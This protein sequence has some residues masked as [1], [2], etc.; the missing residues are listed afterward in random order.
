[1]TSSVDPVPAI[2]AY[3]EAARTLSRL[4]LSANSFTEVMA[5]IRSGLADL[6]AAEKI[7]VAVWADSGQYLQLL[8][9]SFGAPDDLVA[10]SQVDA[11]DQRSGAARVMLTGQAWFTNDAAGHIPGFDQWVHGFGI[12]QL[13]TV[14]LAVE[15][16]RIGV[17]HL[18][19]SPGGFRHADIDV[20]EDLVPFIA[21][22]VEHV[23]RRLRSV[24]KEQLA[25]TIAES[26]AGVASGQSLQQLAAGPLDRFRESIGANLLWITF[27]GEKTARVALKRGFVPSAL[28][29]AFFA[30]AAQPRAA[31]RFYLERPKGVGDAGVA[32]AHVPVVVAGHQQAILSVLRIPGAPFSDEER[33]SLRRLANVTALAWATETY[34]RERAQR[35]RMHERQRIADD[36]HDDVAQTLFSAE[37]TLQSLIEDLGPEDN[38]LAPASRA[39]DL[40]VRGEL[41]LRSAIH[42]LTAPEATRLVDRLAELVQITEEEFAVPVRLDLGRANNDV[43]DSLSPAAADVLLRA[44]REGIVN[45]AKHAG[46]C[47]ISVGL[48][49]TRADRLVLTVV[50]DGVGFD[51][52]ASSTGHGIAALRRLLSPHGGTV[53]VSRRGGAATTMQVTLPLRPPSS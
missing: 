37:M 27:N 35:A 33:Q 20:L 1:M 50:D 25:T 16:A 39:H 11:M 26:A 9:G 12:K 44:A 13:M 41:S 4:S 53:R 28:R 49:A 32:L 15:G 17:L 48:A 40:L 46:P 6:V 22:T 31:T 3:G 29:D 10:S 42:H 36:L 7:G 14:P 8:P 19:N 45:A 38:A 5:G 24:R 52:A 43:V 18:A 23:R 47:R 21:T 51:V 30:D 2:L 34:Q